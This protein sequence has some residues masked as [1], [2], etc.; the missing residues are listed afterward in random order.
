VIYDAVY[1][2]PE[3]APVS[4]EQAERLETVHY[5]RSRPLCSCVLC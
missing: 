5:R 3:W 2:G 1:P 4:F